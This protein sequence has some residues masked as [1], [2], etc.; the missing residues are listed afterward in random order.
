MAMTGSAA[1]AEFRE[2][3][4][5]A[6]DG[7]AVYANLYGDGAHAVVL[8]HGRVFNKE[9]W[10]P[11]AK[12]LL[13]A[14]LRVLA[15][16]FRGYGKSSGEGGYEAMHADVLGAV[17]YLHKSGAQRVSVV[18]GS[19]G[20]GAAARASANSNPG[21]IERLV[22]LAAAPPFDAQK[23]KGRKLFIVSRGDGFA[24]S[25]QKAYEQA[26]EPKRLV[27]LE[28]DAHA[29]HLFATDQGPKVL[30]TIRDW[31]AAE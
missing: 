5:E 8:A 30:A 16:D 28:G 4:F 27:L 19:M 13:R 2:V 23:L 6:S 9:S 24:A 14:G 25:I 10:D 11:Q 12:E 26:A 22:L 29:Q 1:G 20:G 31:L 3:S 17:R 7:A 18:G 21:E 15:I